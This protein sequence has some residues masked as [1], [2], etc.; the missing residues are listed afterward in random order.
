MKKWVMANWKMHGSKKMIDSFMEEF[1]KN[2]QTELELVIF[3]PYVYFD[4]ISSY[5]KEKNISLGAQN[6]SYEDSGAYTGEVSALMLNDFNCKYV[7]IGHSE[8]RTLFHE[9]EDNL[10]KKF[11]ISKEHDIIPVFCIGETLEA[12]K[13]TKTK[14]VLR[15]QL[16]SL[17][18]NADFLFEKCIIAYEPIWAIG[19]GLTPNQNEISQ[20]FEEIHNITTEINKN[21]KVP[22][23]YG[24]SVNENNMNMINSIS[25][26]SGVLVG[27]ASLKVKQFSE[28]IKCIT[29]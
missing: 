3:P 4:Y 14:Q 20:A 11:N 24:G 23:L 21:S 6:V 10:A 15:N 27:G 7:L 1:H 22:M 5:L 29:Y 28:I 8:R 19:T 17:A 18:K 16:E 12:Y 25:H 26:C 13:N 9:D 2:N